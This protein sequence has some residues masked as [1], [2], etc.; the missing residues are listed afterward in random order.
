MRTTVGVTGKISIDLHVQATSLLFEEGR[1]MSDLIKSSIENYVKTKK[2]LPEKNDDSITPTKPTTNSDLIRKL[3]KLS[4]PKATGADKDSGKTNTKPSDKE[5]KKRKRTSAREKYELTLTTIS[6]IA[7]NTDTP[8]IA[9]PSFIKD[10][11]RCIK[12]NNKMPKFYSAIFDMSLYRVVSTKYSPRK[13]NL[14][15]P[16]VT[17]AQLDND[18]LLC[19]RFHNESLHLLRIGNHSDIYE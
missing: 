10:V 19:L 18:W 5:N 8:I 1:T 13:D 2:P 17:I 16:G 14:K 12:R 3:G 7:S 11:K 9:S 4:M 6:K 15:Y